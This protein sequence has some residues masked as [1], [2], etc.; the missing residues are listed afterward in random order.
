MNGIENSIPFFDLSAKMEKSA[1]SKSAEPF[2]I[3]SKNINGELFF[4]TSETYTKINNISCN[5]LQNH[6]VIKMGF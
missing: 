3:R 6:K 5:L 4:P 2:R 1:K